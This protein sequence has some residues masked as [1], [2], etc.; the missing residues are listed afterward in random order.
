M[1]LKLKQERIAR[2]VKKQADTYVVFRQLDGSHVF[3]ETE[4]DD[5]HLTD[6]SIHARIKGENAKIIISSKYGFE[7][8]VTGGK[9]EK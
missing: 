8:E 5:C 7:L 3:C 9:R 6:L 4:E 2:L 1:I